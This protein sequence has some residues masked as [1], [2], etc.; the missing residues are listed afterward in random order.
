[1]E[2]EIGY[3]PGQ[4]PLKGLIADIEAMRAKQNAL[5]IN[6]PDYVQVTSS[7]GAPADPQKPEAVFPIVDQFEV[8]LPTEGFVYDDITVK[9]P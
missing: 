8:T 1:V 9:I 2:G 5:G 7:V 6:G 4:N 3:D